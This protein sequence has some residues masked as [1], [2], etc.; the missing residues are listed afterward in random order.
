MDYIIVYSATF[1]K[2]LERLAAVFDCL[3]KAD[4]KMKASKCQLLRESVR[5]LGHVVSAHGNAADP[6]KVKA[7]ASWLRPG[8][9]QEVRSF[10]GLASYYRRFIAGF[11]DMTRPLVLYIS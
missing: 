7:V 11:A 3:A 5:F 6:E 9:L 10:V 8:N 4:L 2:H 1:D